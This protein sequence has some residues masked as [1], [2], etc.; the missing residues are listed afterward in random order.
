[1]R[2]AKY[3]VLAILIFGLVAGCAQLGL[4]TYSQMTPDE[5]ALSFV[6]TYNKEMKKVFNQMVDPLALSPEL[7]DQ[8]F[9]DLMAGKITADKVPINPKLTAAQKKLINQKRALLIKLKL[10][11]DIYVKTVV[12][13]GLPSAFTEAQILELIDKLTAYG[14]GV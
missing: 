13:G 10:P 3:A 8:M 5:K 6:Q 14:M 4:K 7:R 9:D 2:Q 12:A 1:M 11:L